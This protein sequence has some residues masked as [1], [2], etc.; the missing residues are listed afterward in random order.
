[1]VTMGFVVKD[2]FNGRLMGRGRVSVMPRQSKRFGRTGTLRSLYEIEV[3][4]GAYNGVAKYTDH[5]VPSGID[6]AGRN[7]K[8]CESRVR[9]DGGR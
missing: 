2:W 4:I 6:G 5:L 9:R 7:A 3:R 8:T 1:M